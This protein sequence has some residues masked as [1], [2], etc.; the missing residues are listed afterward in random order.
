[1]SDINAYMARFKPAPRN[2][3]EYKGHPQGPRASS[4]IRPRSNPAVMDNSLRKFDIEGTRCGVCWGTGLLLFRLYRTVPAAGLAISV[5]ANAPVT[6]SSVLGSGHRHKHSVNQN[7]RDRLAML[8]GRPSLQCQ[9]R[10]E[11]PEGSHHKDN[12]GDTKTSA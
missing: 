12:L 10:E 9:P 5:L 6:Y 3:A 2:S 4:P 8:G 1:M 7:L 11:S